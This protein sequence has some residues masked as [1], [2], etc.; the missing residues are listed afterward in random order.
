MEVSLKTGALVRFRPNQTYVTAVIPAIAMS[1]DAVAS[2][3]NLFREDEGGISEAAISTAS[4]RFVSFEVFSG[5]V[6]CSDV[7][8]STMGATNRYPRLGTVSMKIGL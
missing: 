8:S 2:L 6:D 7:P 3:K 1:N 4:T 5:T